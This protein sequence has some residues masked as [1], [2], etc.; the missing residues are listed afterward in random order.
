LSIFA[1]LSLFLAVLGLYGVVTYMV[2]MRVRE[3]GV[4]MALGAQRSDVLVMVLKTGGELA[5]IGSVLGVFITF[6]AGHALSTLLYQ[7]SLYNPATLLSTSALLGTVVLLAS[8]VPARRAAK[9]NPMET[10]RDN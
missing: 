1:G 8:Y 2:K 9:L 3:I 4:R 10:L 7:V 5:L 6:V